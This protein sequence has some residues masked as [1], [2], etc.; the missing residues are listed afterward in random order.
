VEQARLEVEAHESVI[1]V[2]LSVHTEQT[3][4]VDWRA[5]AASLRPHRPPFVRRNEFSAQLR[6]DV[7]T[8]IRSGSANPL[9]IEEARLLDA[10]EYARGLEAYEKAV[11]EWEC[12]VSLANRVLAGE[13][14][15]YSEAVAEFSSLSDLAGLGSSLH[16]AVHD[17]KSVSC[18]L[19]VNGHDVVPE[20]AKSLTASG[21][22]SV[23]RMPKTR[24]HEIYQDYVCGCALRIAREILALLPIDT[25]LVTASVRSEDDHCGEDQE[26]PVLSIAAD[27]LTIESLDFETVDPSDT[28]ELLIHRGDVRASRKNGKFVPI[29]PLTAS[30]LQSESPE[31]N[32]LKNLVSRVQELHTEFRSLMGTT[33][34]ESAEEI[35]SHSPR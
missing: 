25:V 14:G 5:L 9:W 7:A 3:P 15:A 6:Y 13:A 1:E 16:V 10:D 19:A 34:C 8:I 24:F 27:R 32:D 23:K 26:M 4:A 31:R 17:C 2:L 18:T 33:N 28:V 11:T 21:K 20:E 29:V 22:L 35:P 12:T 30:D